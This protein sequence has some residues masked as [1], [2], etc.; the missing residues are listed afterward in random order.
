MEASELCL[1]RE[2][3]YNRPNFIPNFS[4]R[5]KMTLRFRISALLLCLALQVMPAFAQIGAPG[6][7]KG[8]GTIVLRAARIIDGTGAVPITDGA[9]VITD[10]KISTV[11]PFAAISVPAGTR[12]IDLGDATLMPGFIDA[13]THII[14][15]VLGDPEIGESGMRDYTSFGAI[16]ATR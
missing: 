8:T 3:A 14:G 9:I 12:V 5:R 2:G 4:P 16:V 6:E 15:R 1:L 10:D 7:R 13:H 11:G